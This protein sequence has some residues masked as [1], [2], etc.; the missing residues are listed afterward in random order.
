MQEQLL[1]YS[2]VIG[3]VMIVALG[4]Q[5]AFRTESDV[6]A[7][8]TVRDAYPNSLAVDDAGS[9]FQPPGFLFLPYVE[10]ALPTPTPK[11]EMLTVS[12]TIVSTGAAFN[13]VD[14][15]LRRYNPDIPN[16][17]GF[18]DAQN[19]TLTVAGN[20]IEYS[21]LDAPL[22]EPGYFYFIAYFN[23]NSTAG[24][25]DSWITSDAVNPPSGNRIVMPTFDIADVTLRAPEDGATKSLPEDFRWNARGT[26]T[27]NYG[28]LLIEVDGEGNVVR[29]AGVDNLL[30][31]TNSVTI[32]S[33]EDEAGFQTNVEYSWRILVR[34][35]NGGVGIPTEQRRI[36]FAE[37]Q[38]AEMRDSGDSAAVKPFTPVQ[39]SP[40]QLQS[41]RL[42]DRSQFQLWRR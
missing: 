27:D 32:G 35:G 28:L 20:S 42:V 3:V 41:H 18:V 30:H 23:L 34:D 10:K 12:G 22:L 39:F 1:K 33:I 38:G 19:L 15:G 37:L 29:D 4:Q 26:A 13:V 5:F 40:Q 31:P 17:A 21:F 8:V 36:T 25:L 6:E 11:P 24:L 9:I 14:I 2:A 16:S 7:S